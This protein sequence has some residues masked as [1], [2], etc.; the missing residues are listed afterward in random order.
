MKLIKPFTCVPPGE[1]YP[2]ELPKGA[3]CPPDA[4]VAAREAGALAPA[5]AANAE[6]SAAKSAKRSRR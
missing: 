1:I 6:K 3:E 2:V 5:P 4:E